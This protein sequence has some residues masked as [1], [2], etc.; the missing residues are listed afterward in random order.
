L[1]LEKELRGVAE[2]IVVVGL[3]PTPMLTE[4]VLGD[5]ERPPTQLTV[6]STGG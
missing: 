2:D 1:L 6:Y 4:P 5:I 3:I